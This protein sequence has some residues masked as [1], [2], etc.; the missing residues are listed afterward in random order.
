MDPATARVS[1]TD[2]GSLQAPQASLDLSRPI[3]IEPD[4]GVVIGIR[5]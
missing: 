4:K 1:L 3:P 2:V 5:K